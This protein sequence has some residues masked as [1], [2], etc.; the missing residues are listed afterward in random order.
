MQ[1]H[2]YFYSFRLLMGWFSNRWPFKDIN[3]KLFALGIK[4]NIKAIKL[5]LVSIFFVGFVLAFSK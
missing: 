5:L 3:A 2:E 1:S 4:M